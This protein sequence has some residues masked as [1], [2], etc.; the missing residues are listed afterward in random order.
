[1][2]IHKIGFISFGGR[3]S[4]GQPTNWKPEE[5][6]ST[7]PEIEPRTLLQPKSLENIPLLIVRRDELLLELIQEAASPKNKKKKTKKKGVSPTNKLNELQ[8]AIMSASPEELEKLL[9]ERG[10]LSKEG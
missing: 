2:E 3:Y 4:T 9:E 7:L 8:Q 6:V 1:M 10:L 5:V